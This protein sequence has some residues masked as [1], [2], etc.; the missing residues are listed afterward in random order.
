VWTPGGVPRRD[1]RDH[2]RPPRSITAH[3]ATEPGSERSAYPGWL[4]SV[5][6]ERI[7][8]L[9]NQ[10][11]TISYTENSSTVGGPPGV[12]PADSMAFWTMANTGVVVLS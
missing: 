12:T 10:G 8:R 3:F 4:P 9:C 1:D 5:P 6:L 7:Q 11:W 2:D